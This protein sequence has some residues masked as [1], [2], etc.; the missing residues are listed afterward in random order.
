MKIQMMIKKYSDRTIEIFPKVTNGR[1]YVR[2]YPNG[3]VVK[4][5][6][7][8]YSGASHMFRFVERFY[9]KWNVD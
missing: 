6:K 9:N 3:E 1:I 4:F 2:I 5:K 8:A 7:S